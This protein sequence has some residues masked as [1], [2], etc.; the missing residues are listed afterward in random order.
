MN[1][2]LKNILAVIVGWLVGGILNMVLVII[3]PMLIP[4]PPGIDPMD[5][6]SLKAGIPLLENRHFIFP[7]L[8][9]GLGTLLGALV[10]AKMAAAR[11]FA[12]SMLVGLLFFA[13]GLYNVID[14]GGP[15]WF[16][17]ADLILAYFPMAYLGYKLGTK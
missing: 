4:L 12:L 6:E 17:G 2:I 9:H 15:T 11:P 13:G 5:P 10:A 14:M 3:G 7:L 1:P 16:K 8:A